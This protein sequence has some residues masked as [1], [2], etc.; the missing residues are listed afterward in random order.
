MGNCVCYL[1]VI[2]I[3]NLYPLNTFTNRLQSSLKFVYD[4]LPVSFANPNS[5]VKNYKML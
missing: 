4:N 5:V 2:K 1:M 3:H